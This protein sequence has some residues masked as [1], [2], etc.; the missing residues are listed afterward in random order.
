VRKKVLDK[1]R[2]RKRKI[3]KILEDLR[4]PHH[5]GPVFHAS[6]IDYDVS[7]RIDGLACGG[8]GAIMQTVRSLGLAEAIDQQLHL[9]KIYNPYMESDHVLNMAFNLLAGGECLDDLERLRN[10]EVYLS[11]L[12]AKRIPDPTT[13]G[14]FCRRFESHHILTLMHVINDIRLEVW[15]QQPDSFFDEAII[16]VD[17][18][19]VPT[20]GE[21]KEGVELSYD[22]VWCYH[23]LVVSLANTGEVLF[24]VN[25]SGAR[26]SH[27][28]AAEYLDMAA[29]LCERAGFRQITFRGDTDF[30]QTAHLDRWAAKGYRFIFGMD[31]NATLVGWSEDIPEEW[32]HPLDR[33]KKATGKA[34]SRRRPENVKGRIVKEKELLNL[35][36]NSEDVGEF[37]YQP[38]KCSTT[39]QVVAVRKNI[40]RQRGELMLVDEIRYFFYITNDAALA[41]EA[42]IVRKANGR[43][44][45]ENLI[46][47]L[48]NG[49]PALRAP[50]GDLTSN[51]AYMV[52]A[53]LAWTFKVWFALLLPAAGR[54][55]EKQSVLKMEFK[56]FLHVFMLVPCQLVRQGRKLIYR[57]LSWNPWQEVLLRYV[58]AV[59]SPIRC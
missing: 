18:T 7:D 44:N 40:S 2:K 59:R 15:Q 46:D 52:M 3:K 55:G 31:A 33:A 49:V 36:L 50:L 38:G 32:W 57:L 35:R 19:H 48:K 23:P 14:D 12:D 10:D 56:K 42:E 27:E 9:L 24:I 21:C 8:I 47:Q 45:Q 20:Y 13:A 30:S 6:N 29:E 43:C 11:A 41:T 22:G 34:C 4:H 25:R 37:D 17:G 53:S 51:W 54:W 1:S 28:G 58:N 26:P 16:D 39:Y 5:D